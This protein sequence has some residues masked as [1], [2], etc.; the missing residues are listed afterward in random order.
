MKNQKNTLI[1]LIL[2]LLTGCDQHNVTW[3]DNHPDARDA[4]RH[5]CEKMSD[6]RRKQDYECMSA[7]VSA[8][9]EHS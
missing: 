7:G 6:E 9:K 5:R 8:T 4:K 2:C 3:Y 1:A